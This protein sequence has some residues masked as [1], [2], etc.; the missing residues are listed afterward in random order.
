MKRSHARP[1][2]IAQAA[3]VALILG[4]ATACGGGG[5]EA[6]EASGSAPGGDA[7]G[8]IGSHLEA[9]PAVIQ[10][11]ADGSYASPDTGEMVQ[12]A[13]SGSGFII[14]PSGIAVTNAHVVEG[15]GSIDVY[16]GGATDPINAKILGVSECNDLA[17]IDLN[18]EAF[19]FLS[20]ASDAVK[21][22]TNVWAAGFPLGDPQYTIVDGSI[23]KEKAEGDTAW[24]SLDFT[25]QHTAQIQPGN[26]GG[27]LI[28][29]DGRVV[30]VNYAGFD[31]GTGTEQFFAI[32]ATLAKS[33]VDVLAKGQDQDSI[34]VNG[35]AF[36]NPDTGVAGVWVYG[37]R[38]GSPAS[39]VGVQPGDIVLQL[40]GRDVVKAKDVEAVGATKAGYCDVLR[41]KGTDKPIKIQVLRPGTGE[42]LEGELNNPDKTLVA[43]SALSNEN[44][45]GGGSAEG[46]SEFVSVTDNTGSLS[47]DIPATWGD[48]NVEASGDTVGMLVASSNLDEYFD[49]T[50]SGVEY[51]LYDGTL[52]QKAME[53]YLKDIEAG[54]GLGSVTSTCQE[55]TDYEW[56][57]AGDFSYLGRDYQGCKGSD[58]NLYIEIRS[59]PAQG[60][61]VLLACQYNTDLDVEWL[62]RSISSLQVA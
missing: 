20:W 59:Y 26:S 16:V 5:G 32:P 6:T 3:G 15:A 13:G 42:V 22:A 61:Y 21:A 47:A 36:Y 29:E 27:P 24:A 58:M 2:F 7:A 44:T 11:V 8:A 49:G 30:G 41:T 18:G 39:N 33:I 48:L 62:N 28:T 55:S 46:S 9:Q 35:E 45:T 12:E 1:W 4:T 19:P 17:V 37:V 50:I 53:G 40:E 51:Y 23:A 43:I 38:S 60:K 10:I 25:L 14:D 54:D 56:T 52:D 31:P 34:G 57:D